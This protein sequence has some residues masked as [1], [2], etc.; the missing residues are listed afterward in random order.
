M[1]FKQHVLNPSAPSTPEIGMH[2]EL[3]D[4][5]EQAMAEAESSKR[6]AFEESTRRSRAEKDAIESKRRVKA[7]EN[8]YN[9]ELRQRRDIAETLEKTKEEHERNKKELNEVSKKLRMEL[10]QKLSLESQIA[11]F[12]HTVQELEQKMLTA[13]QMLQNYK[14]ERDELQE[15]CDGALKLV[16]ELKE[17]HE[18]EVS[19]SSVTQFYTEFDFSEVR[20]ATRNFDP[21]LKIGEGDYGSTFRGFLQHTEVAV[22]MLYAHS[23]QGPSEFQQE[24]NVLCKLRHPNLVAVIGACPDARIIIYEYLSGGNLENRLNCTDKNLSLSWQ[25]RICIAAELCSVLI[26]LHSCGVVHGDL[27]PNKILFD[28]NMVTKLS[29]FGNYHA[30]SQNEVS[31]DSMSFE[32]DMRSDTYAFGIILLRLLTGQDSSG[33]LKEEVQYALNEKKLDIMLDSTAGNW[34]FVQAQQLATLAM[35]CCDGVSKNRPDIAFEVWRVLEPMRISCGLSSSRSIFKGQQQIPSYFICPIS[36]ETMQDPVVAADGYTYEAE[37]LQGWFDSGHDTSP[38][39]N[40]KLASTD[41][42]P[43]HALRSA[44]QEWLQQP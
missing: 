24:V 19:N 5:I 29:D 34:P 13:I 22:K 4:Q 28:K 12:D 37:V 3:F 44:I 9:E 40:L 11:E 31:S 35:N 41:L 1:P 27:K 32:S 15:K 10:E 42:V 6:D 26:F 21:F 14:K 2:D 36:Q 39:T 16:D 17:K 25:D 23:L 30:I 20:D 38:M 43:N 33:L 18:K 8:M 7:S